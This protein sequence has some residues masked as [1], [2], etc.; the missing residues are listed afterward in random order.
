[1]RIVLDT[2]VLVSAL[3]TRGTPPDLLDE[4]WI[5]SEFQ[6]VTSRTHLAEL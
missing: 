4:S 5:K 6:L 2:N 3:I 1:M